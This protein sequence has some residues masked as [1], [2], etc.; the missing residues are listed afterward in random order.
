ME[1]MIEISKEAM[2]TTKWVDSVLCLVLFLGD[3]GLIAIAAYVLLDTSNIILTFAILFAA[4]ILT[5]LCI[6]AFMLMHIVRLKAVE[7]VK[8]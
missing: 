6:I 8:R 3:M 4:G 7:L 1:S 2:K 5:V